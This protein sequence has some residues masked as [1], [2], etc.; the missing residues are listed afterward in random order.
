VGD[1]R[2]GGRGTQWD[3]KG[4]E[5]AVGLP[6]VQTAVRILGGGAIP[7][8]AEPNARGDACGAI[9][10]KA[11]VRVRVRVEGVGGLD[12]QTSFSGYYS[13]EI[14]AGLLAKKN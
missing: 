1:G 8:A 10:G 5:L 11:R 7:G 6:S 13:T 2:E 3:G 14:G 4:E 9:H 12:W